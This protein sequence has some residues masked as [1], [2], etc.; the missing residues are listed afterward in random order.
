MAR[1]VPA[2][3]R[4]PGLRLAGLASPGTRRVLESM[5]VRYKRT[6]RGTVFSAFL[7]PLLFLLAMGVGLGELVDEGRGSNAGLRGVSYLAFIAPGLLVATAMQTAATESTWPVMGGIKWLRTYH[8]ML[9]SPIGVDEVLW[10]HL[11]WVI[12]RLASSSAIFLTV[13]ALF[14][15]ADSALVVLALPAAVLTGMAFAAPIT[16]FAAHRENDADFA[17]LMRF[18]ILPMFLFSGTFF[19]VSQ[20]PAALRPLA[21]VTPLWHGVEL[22]RGLAL[23]RLGGLSGLAHLAY[24]LVW[25]AAGVLLAQAAFRRRLVV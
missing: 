11:W 14:G 2:V 4:R 17:L 3:A 23:G 12:L 1:W 13:I 22:A 16:A 25:I 6:W 20:L 18:G 9:A 19:P 5:L 8:A 24:L 10:G 7:S 15:A 21:W